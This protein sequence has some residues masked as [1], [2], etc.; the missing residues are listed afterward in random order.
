MASGSCWL[1]S[2][3]HVLASAEIAEGRRHRLVGL[4]GR[5]SVEGAFVIPRC[6]WVHT[7][8]MKM[9]LDVAHVDASGTVL[10]TVRM[11]PHRV[12]APMRRAHLVIEAEAGA[13]ERWGLRAGDIVEVRR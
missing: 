4:L 13:F 7:F 2:E 12:G 3:G 1:V 5:T 8:G 11:V 10:R 6:R 9:P